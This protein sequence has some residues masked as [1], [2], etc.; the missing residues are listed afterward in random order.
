MTRARLT[1][2]I[3]AR[4]RVLLGAVLGLAAWGVAQLR[5]WLPGASYL[6]GWDTAAVAFL[7]PTWRMFLFETEHGLRRHAAREDENRM[8]LFTII[9]IAVAASFGAIVYALRESKTE[10]QSGTVAMAIA[11]LALSWLVVQSL[12]T[13]HYAHRCFGDRDDDG[14][15]DGGIKFSGEP[16]S[17]YRDFV[18]VAICIGSTFQVSDFNI[19][20]RRLR[21]LVTVHALVS[22]VF[23]TMVLALG[24]NIV[25]NLLGQ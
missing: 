22:F 5:G 18:Y 15:T 25:G 9:L 20:S 11:T 4:G 13:L 24:I 19:T 16:P 3:R 21:D 23:N 8:V 10:H 14:Q 2:F 12:F 7:I 17:T 6:A 1:H